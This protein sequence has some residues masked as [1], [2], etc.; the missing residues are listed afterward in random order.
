MPK[1]CGTDRLEP[2][3]P[4]RLRLACDRPKSWVA[5]R[6]AAQGSPMHPG[7]AV[8]WEDE[9]W[10]VVV[11]EARPGGAVRYELARWDD[12][13]A[14]R[15]L[16]P[17]D[18]TSEAERAADARDVGRRRVAAWIAF[19]L[20]PVVGLL[21]GRVQ[22]RLGLEL[23][24]RA[25]RLTL[26]SI[27]VP[28]AVG[29]YSVVMSLA[30]GFGAGTRLATVD[31]GPLL[32]FLSYFLPESFLRLAV[33]LAQDRPIGSILGIPLYLLARVTGLVGPEPAPPGPVEPAGAQRLA[34]RYLL[35]EPLLSFLPVADQESLWHS[36]GFSPVTWGKR[37]A[38]FLLVYPGL[39]APAQAAKLAWAGGGFLDVLLL[40]ATLLLAAEQ[41][42]RLRAL[43]RGQPAPSFLG[44][45][46]GP[47]ARPLLVPESGG[48]SP[49]VPPSAS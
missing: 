37:T 30:A 17:Y 29:T 21:P 27:L 24:I 39:T 47:F 22:E 1:A 9:L 14:I 48:G 26:A 2:G 40:A 25:S 28:F 41:V 49:G 18:E 46:V 10:E 13:H 11:A 4:G 12:Q 23:G 44:H 34:D 6:P 20:A 3:P 32:P 35:I 33:V 19:L 45:L 31:P 7:T 16:L 42:R 43:G 5:R 36:R 15:V 8:R 38:W